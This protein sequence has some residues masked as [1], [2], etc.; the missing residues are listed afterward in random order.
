M[1]NYLQSLR[2]KVFK[3]KKRCTKVTYETV[4]K[5]VRAMNILNGNNLCQKK[6]KNYYYCE[7]CSS[8]HLT[9]MDKQL[10][11]IVNQKKYKHDKKR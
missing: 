10:A 5:A 4:E 8:Y 2:E 9:S 3:T 7:E 11:K 1:V 6:I